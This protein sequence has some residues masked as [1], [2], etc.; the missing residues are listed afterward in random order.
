VNPIDDFGVSQE[1]PEIL[2]PM[3]II[4]SPRSAADES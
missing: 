2:Q 1:L 4:N 3:R